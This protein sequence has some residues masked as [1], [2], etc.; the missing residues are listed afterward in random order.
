MSDPM[1]DPR[2]SAQH[3]KTNFVVGCHACL[4]EDALSAE[5]D[6]LVALR[7]VNQISFLCILLL[8]SFFHKFALITSDLGS[9]L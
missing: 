2:P 5:S 8:A 3:A 9:M 7:T 6:G 4:G 1:A